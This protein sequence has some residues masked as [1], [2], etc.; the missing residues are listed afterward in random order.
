[1][2]CFRVD[3]G[4]IESA[5]KKTAGFT[6]VSHCYQRLTHPQWPYSL[7]VMVHGRSRSES[8]TYVRTIAEGIGCTDYLV[9]YS[10]EEL[11]KERVKYFR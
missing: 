11:K 9:L 8:D 5:G 2:V 1:M 10:T 4:D 3:E 7:F 6:F